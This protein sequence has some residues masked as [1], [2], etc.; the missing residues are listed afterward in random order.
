[1]YHLTI[2]DAG[3]VLRLEAPVTAS[4]ALKDWSAAEAAGHNVSCRNELGAPMSKARL[5]K[6]TEKD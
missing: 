4:Q 3:K 5:R 2:L 6:L 1:M